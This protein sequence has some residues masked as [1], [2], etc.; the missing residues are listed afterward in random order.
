MTGAGHHGKGAAGSDARGGAPL[1]GLRAI[2]DGRGVEA[3][4]LTSDHAIG[5]YGTGLPG[6]LAR[7]GALVVTARASVPVSGSDP[8]ALWSGVAGVVG[9]GRTVGYQGDCLTPQDR[10]AMQAA[11]APRH[12]IDVGPDILRQIGPC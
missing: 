1:L 8:A 3:V 9:R 5:W 6:A 12:A 2:M 11:L 4:V 10:A 7:P